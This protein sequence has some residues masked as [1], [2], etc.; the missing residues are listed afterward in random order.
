MPT[1]DTRSKLAKEAIEGLT[2]DKD[3]PDRSDWEP[4]QWVEYWEEQN[5]MS[6]ES[7]ERSQ[8]DTLDLLGIEE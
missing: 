1:W 6:R 7:Y 5:R 8:A 2:E 4:H 3:V